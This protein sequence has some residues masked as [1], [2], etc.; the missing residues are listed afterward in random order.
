MIAHARLPQP[1]FG[2]ASTDGTVLRP[3]KKPSSSGAVAMKSR[4]VVITA[5]PCLAASQK[6]GP[7]YTICRW[8]MKMSWVLQRENVIPGQGGFGA[9]RAERRRA[10]DGVQ[11]SGAY[12]VAAGPPAARPAPCAPDSRDCGVAA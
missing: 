6:M 5:L 10:R 3:T 7:A 11:R 2:K 1:S 12:R 4:Y 9:W 8:S